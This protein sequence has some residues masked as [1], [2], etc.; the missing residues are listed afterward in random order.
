MKTFAYIVTPINIKQLKEGWESLKFIPDYILSLF[1]K[2]LP[3]YKIIKIGRFESV[4]GDIIKGYKIVC[5]VLDER[6][7]E[8]LVLERIISA[9]RIAEGI[10]VKLI[11]LGNGTALIADK[12]YNKIFKNIKT[13]VTSGNALTAWCIFERYR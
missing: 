8:N 11:G 12:N 1:C 2:L 13:P 7:Q 5:P 4:Q 9:C 10:G 6:K 3:K